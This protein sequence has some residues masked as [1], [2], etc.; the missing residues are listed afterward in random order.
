MDQDRARVRLREER[1]AVEQLKRDI[2]RDSGEDRAATQ[3]TG[4][5]A[6]PAPGFEAEAVDD[7]VVDQLNER[8][9][10]LDR[11]ESRLAGGTYGLST[12]SGRPIPDERLEA[13]PA[14][15]LTVDEAADDERASR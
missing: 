12:R 6:D 8:L 14:A 7:A 5:A 15:E 10:A 3:E 1:A 2:T 4:D 11:A 13:D 9:A